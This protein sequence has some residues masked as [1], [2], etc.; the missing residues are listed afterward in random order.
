MHYPSVECR[1]HAKLAF[2]FDV[3]SSAS[4]K[5]VITNCLPISPPTVTLN[6]FG[7]LTFERRAEVLKVIKFL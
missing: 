5:D 1:M 3:G 6:L 4:W 2:H 7:K